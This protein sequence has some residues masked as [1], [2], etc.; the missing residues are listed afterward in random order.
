MLD[1]NKLVHLLD[2]ISSQLF[3]GQEENQSL[4]ALK[5]WE[6]ITTDQCFVNRVTDS[7]SSFLLPRWQGNLSDVF[8]A[9]APLAEYT[10]LGVDG[11]QVYP[12]RH[13]SGVGCFVV[14]TGGC[15][16]RYGQQSSVEFF[17][18]P[19]VFTPEKFIEDLG[20]FSLDMVDLKREACEFETAFEKAMHVINTWKNPPAVGQRPPFVFLFDGSLIFWHLEGKP[21]EVC[22]AFL[23]VYMDYLQK[24]YDNAIVMAGYISM[25]KSKEL[26]NLTRIGLCR[27]EKANC[28]GCYSAFADFPCKAVD[29]VIDA[30]LCKL[31]LP[32]FGRTTIFYSTSKII[33][34]YPPHLKPAFFYLDV[35]SE[36]VR[37]EIPAWVANDPSAIDLV[38]AVALD[39]A[40]KGRGYPVAL[41]EAHEQAVIRGADRDFFYHVMSKRSL[42]HQRRVFM[43]PKSIKKKGI[44]I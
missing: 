29:Q 44:G 31:L 14:N 5:T 27:F 37:I 20:H 15:L 42:E 34:H 32:E 3:S 28:I 8:E 11:S 9:P 10:V 23:R 43:S 26:V 1:R 7:E 17:S 16:L 22:D 12:E 6:A 2:Q 35:G 38:C 33:E 18:V 19:Q 41:A 21:Q 13:L 30:Q 40:N 4:L 25:P 39:Q 24:F 36:V